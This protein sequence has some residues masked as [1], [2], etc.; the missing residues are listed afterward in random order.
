MLTM[1]KTT[2]L[3]PANSVIAKM[4]GAGTVS[5]VVGKH[6]SR[7]YR[8]MHPKERGGTGGFVPHEDAVKLL[9]YAQLNEIKLCPADF[10]RKLTTERFDDMADGLSSE[11]AAA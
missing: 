8:W 6:V 7:V 3:E 9:E 10:F 2:G 4:G 5:T 11:G 1:S